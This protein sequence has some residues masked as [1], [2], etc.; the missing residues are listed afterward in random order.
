MLGGANLENLQNFTGNTPVFLKLPKAKMLV[1]VVRRL[2]GAQ[3]GQATAYHIG[4]A[5]VAFLG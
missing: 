4:A 2:S 1:K 3:F 5:H